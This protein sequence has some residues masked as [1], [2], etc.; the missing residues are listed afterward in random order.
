MAHKFLLE[1]AARFRKD[2]DLRK[3]V[4]RHMGHCIMSFKDDSKLCSYLAKSGHH[5]SSGARGLERE[6]KKVK[7]KARRRYNCIQGLVTEDMN[8]GPF[9]KLEVRLMLRGDGRQ[10]IRVIQKQEG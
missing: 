7:R 6:V 1:K 2:I 5:R 4:I 9:E 3:E 8:K 10:D